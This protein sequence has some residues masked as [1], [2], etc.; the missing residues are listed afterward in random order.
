MV[1]MKSQNSY[2]KIHQN[3]K[4]LAE[5]KCWRKRKEEKEAEAEKLISVWSRIPPTDPHQY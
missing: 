5:T 4:F 2:Y 1:Y 3:L